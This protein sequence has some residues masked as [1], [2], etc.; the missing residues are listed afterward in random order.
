ML[1]GL[2]ANGITALSATHWPTPAGRAIA[3]ALWAVVA[4]ALVSLVAVE[5]SRK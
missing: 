2:C 1:L 5:L 3:L 4:A